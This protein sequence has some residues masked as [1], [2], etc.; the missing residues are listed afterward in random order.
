[1]ERLAHMLEAL[2]VLFGLNYWD[3]D[4]MI[5]N[6]SLTITVVIPIYTVAPYVERLH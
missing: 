1:M 4:S 3:S 2:C 5:T 6:G